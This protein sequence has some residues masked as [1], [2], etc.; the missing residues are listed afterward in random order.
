MTLDS[1]RRRDPTARVD[2]HTI[3]MAM[4]MEATWDTSN[5]SSDTATAASAHAQRQHRAR[6]DREWAE[7]HSSRQAAVQ[8]PLPI[9]LVD[10]QKKNPPTHAHI[11]GSLRCVTSHARMSPLTKMTMQ[12]EM[13]EMNLE[14]NFFVGSGV[15]VG[16]SEDAISLI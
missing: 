14:G 5:T 8:R 11:Y 15:M 13:A 16:V 6:T 12:L 3:S 2:V 9:P 4:G 10:K 1:A 7:L